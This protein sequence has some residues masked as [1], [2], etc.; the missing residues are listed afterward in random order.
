MQFTT[1][2]DRASGCE[3]CRR[4]LP[5]CLHLTAAAFMPG[6]GAPGG[7]D[8][9]H[10]RESPACLQFPVAAASAGVDVSGGL[11][12]EYVQLAGATTL[13][14]GGAPGGLRGAY[15][16]EFE[17]SG[18]GCGSRLGPAKPPGIDG[19]STWP[20]LSQVTAPPRGSMT[21]VLRRAARAEVA[22]AAARS[23]GLLACGSQV[24]ELDALVCFRSPWHVGLADFA[25]TASVA[26]SGLALPQCVSGDAAVE[27][28]T[29][30]G[31]EGSCSSRNSSG[32]SSRRRNLSA[33]LRSE[34]P[35]GGPPPRGQCG[36]DPPCRLAEGRRR[37]GFH[38]SCEAGFAE[39]LV[40]EDVSAAE[41][42][43]WQTSSVAFRW[44][45]SCCRQSFA[46]GWTGFWLKPQRSRAS[47]LEP[48]Q[49][50]GRVDPVSREG[51][52]AQLQAC[53]SLG[54]AA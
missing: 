28:V 42:F 19:S 11:G 38:R 21:Q 14:G 36:L 1:S 47:W 13:P 10:L 54:S 41:A 50:S 23:P 53:C 20:V 40:A 33:D 44:E 22:G 12:G 37:T 3:C 5:V 24:L 30:A 7:V 27:A 48:V 34:H 49:R 9:E 16:H 43:Y 2:E 31:S 18:D 4:E 29:S 26:G 52:E 39:R 35:L 8:G 17:Q 51:L 25:A 32:S 15:D 45:C 6:S 46:A